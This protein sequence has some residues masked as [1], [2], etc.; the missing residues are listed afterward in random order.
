[1]KIPGTAE[2]I[3]AIRQMVSEG[4][5]INITLIFSLTRYDEVIEAYL[6]G[7][8]AYDGDLSKVRSVA[9]FFVSRVDT[10][11]DRRL[12]AIGTDEALGLRGH[13]AVAQAKLAYQLFTQR[14][15]GGRWE[16]L[17]E[18][19]ANLQR[20]L[21]ASTSTKNPAY[22]DL[23]Y[24]DTLV[25][26]D[27]VNTMPEATLEAFE[28]HGTIARRGRRRGLLLQIVRRTH[29][30][31]RAQERG[32]FS[33]SEQSELLERLLARDAGLWPKGNVSAN[34]L[35]W[36]DVPKR[37]RDEAAD[38]RAWALSVDAP[39]VLL[40]GMGGSSL[41][42]EALHLCF[43][44][45]RLV[46]LDTTD[47]KTIAEAPVDDP[48]FIVSSKSGTTLEVECLLAHFWKRF[49][50]GRRFAAITDPGTP[51]A[52]LATERDFR[53]VF[54]NPP[55]IGGRYSVLS[56][57]GLVPAALMG[58]D[59]GELCH[60]A[61]DVEKDEAVELGLAM[62]K[63]ALE[64]RDKLTV[65][66]PKPFRSLSL[67]GEQLVAESTGKQGKGCVP[68]PTTEPEIGDDRHEVFLEIDEPLDLGAQFQRWEIAT[69]IAGH[70]LQIDPFDEPNV[71]ESKK[72]TNDVLANLP[73][74]EV[75]NADP[76]AVSQWLKETVRPGDYVSLQAYVPFAQDDTLEHL[77][78]GLRDG[79]GGMAVTVGYGPRF[80]HSTGQLHKGGPDEIVAVQIVTRQ[81]TA[82][83]PIPDHAYDFGTLIAAQSIGDLK[84]LKDHG[85][86]V[87][88]VAVDDLK[89]VS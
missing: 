82:D 27:T 54:L 16:E 42:S 45:E 72:N 65:V 52:K 43:G 18:R 50:D 28:D 8:E 63:A 57:F 55:D 81:P 4:R 25:G 37:M 71:T 22:D 5:N 70:V 26:P 11:V 67:W 19:G 6:S 47:P 68:V 33:L 21:W 32:A 84:S 44:D 7:L 49:P 46:V 24:V 15:R 30:R 48:F 62:G 20:P 58:I 73:L 29:R 17:R 88:R 36:L 40:L 85:R 23:L 34:R 51:L 12:E 39:Q 38:L 66:A 9:S 3:P 14:F 56:Y 35:G 77:R 86:R 1:V 10:E 75:D 31:P 41:G 89:E 83:L 76:G 60:R 13:A 74:P 59:I 78:R 64:G 69:A 53:R 80:L 87:L 2:G 61:I 79:L